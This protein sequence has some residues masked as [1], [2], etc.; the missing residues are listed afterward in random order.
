MTILERIVTAPSRVRQAT[1]TEAEFC[2]WLA[3]VLLFLFGA[4]EVLS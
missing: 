1:M 4:L 2:G 3:I